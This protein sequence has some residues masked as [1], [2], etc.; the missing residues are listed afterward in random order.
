MPGTGKRD[1]EPRVRTRRRMFSPSEIL[2]NPIELDLS[3]QGSI[4]CKTVWVSRRLPRLSVLQSRPEDADADV[5]VDVDVLCISSAVHEEGNAR[6]SSIRSF[7]L[8]LFSISGK[9]LRSAAP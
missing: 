2:Q 9:T 5:D 3:I 6:R 8:N 1:V 4:D 7:W